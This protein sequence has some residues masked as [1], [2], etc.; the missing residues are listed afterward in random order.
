MIGYTEADLHDNK[1]NANYITPPEYDKVTRWA[2]AQLKEHGVCPPFEKEYIKKDGSRI[3]VLMGSALLEDDYTADAVTYIINI[4]EQKEIE[5]KRK[6]LQGL[7]KKQQDEF[8][9]IFMNAPALITIR[10]GQQLR[11]DFVNKAFIDFYGQRDYLGKTAEEVHI[12]GYEEHLKEI[13]QTVLQSGES[14]I[15]RAFKIERLDPISHHK[16]DCWLDFIYTPV[17]ADNGQIDGIAFFGFDVSDLVKAQ[18]ATRQ[19]MQKKDEFMSIASHELKTPITSLKGSL[20]IIQRLAG[21]NTEVK[22]I[23]SFIDKASKQTSRLTTLVDDLLDVTRIQQGKMMFNYTR[24]NAAEAIAE[25]V[26]EAQASITSHKIEILGNPAVE[27]YAD[28]P[29]L[30]QVISNFLSNAVKYSPDA[31]RVEV[32]AEATDNGMLRVSVKDFGIGI[33]Q[34]KKNHVF[35]RFFRVQESSHKFSGLGLGLYISAEIVY[36]HDGK[37]G[38]ESTENEGSTFW[39]C[40]PVE[41]K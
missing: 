17:Y 7:I 29:R 15:G 26:E 39:F 23:Y 18:Q 28:R 4:T 41:R 13:E 38:V 2:I 24:F 11:Y 40:I 8:Q 33:P 31:D 3:T 16:V 27:I 5:K 20:Q 10:R 30:E 32:S 37:I 19:L 14:Y 25:C 9:S 21:K 12:M 6:E 36:R 35:D 22:K 34:D 1:L